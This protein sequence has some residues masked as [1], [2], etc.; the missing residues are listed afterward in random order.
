MKALGL[1]LIA[2]VIGC[3]KKDET[4][5]APAPS[6]SAPVAQA[7]AAPRAV[8][9]T[10]VTGTYDAKQADVR[11][12][13]DAPPFLHPEGKEASGPGSIEL[14][15]PETTG[16]VSGKASG[17]LGAQTFSG[18][19]EDGRLTGTLTPS[20]LAGAPTWGVVEGAVTGSGGARVVKGTIRA[21]G[22]DGRVVR[23]ANFEL[24]PKSAT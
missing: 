8:A 2:V 1:L 14:T 13:K 3:G 17:A 23:E 9:K 19:L 24:A 4:P 18:W 6:A 5:P 20:E 15:L 12:P 11:T 10:V 21:S 7:S 22:P 16:A